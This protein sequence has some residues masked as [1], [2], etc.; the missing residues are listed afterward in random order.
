MLQMAFT[1][2]AA[3]FQVFFACS[4]EC[5]CECQI[6]VSMGRLSDVDCFNVM[7][8]LSDPLCQLDISIRQVVRAA[9]D[10]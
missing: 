5:S 8:C 2:S 1:K 4:L 10:D 7:A 9:R 6:P 3:V